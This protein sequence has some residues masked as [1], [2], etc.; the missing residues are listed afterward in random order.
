MKK[1][2]L[3]CAILSLTL[4][5]CGEDSNQENNNNPD[6][7]SECGNSV[8][9]GNEACDD[10]N[11][12]GGD[13]CSADCMK[14]E[15]GYTCP[16]SGGACSS[17]TP[18]EKK[19][20]VCGNGLVEKGEI[21]D[22]NNTND[23]DGC[24]KSC[25]HIE[26]GYTC[27]KK[28]GECSKIETCGNGNLDDNEACD[29]NNTK[30][31]DGCSADCSTVESGFHCD[32]PG[33]PC[34]SNTCN[35][36][37]INPDS[38]EECDDGEDNIEYG[39]EGMCAIDCHPAHYCGDKKLD[40]IDRDNGEECDAG[41]DTSS[42]YNGCTSTC[43]RI[44]Y[45]GD[46]KIQPDHEECD[47][48]N[49]DDNDGCSSEC[50]LE[51]NFICV[52]KNGKSVCNSV[53]C[54]NGKIDENEGCDDGNRLNGDGCSM[55]CLNEKGF[56]CHTNDSGTS[57]CD[58]TCGNG[59]LDKD[60]LET[61]D[62]GNT[63]DGDGCSAHCTI[64][65]GYIC[66]DDGC[67]AR[68]CSDGII[69]GNEECDDGNTID[70]DGC[71]KWCKRE[72]GWHCPTAGK[73]LKDECGDGIVTGDE[74]CDEGKTNTTSGCLN[75]QIQ[76]GW[77][78]PVEN[79]PCLDTADCGNGKMEGIE[80]CD[81]FNTV[82]GDGCSN[83]CEIETGYACSGTP[84]VCV[85]GP[86][87]DGII[88]AGE[89]CD[90]KNNKAGDGCSPECTSEMFFDCSNGICKPR[91]GDGMTMDAEECDDGNLIAGDGCSPLCKTEPGFACVAPQ[92]ELPDQI[93]LPMICR[94]FIA[95]SY[96]TPNRDKKRS[97]PPDTDPMT[98]GYVS[99][100]LYASLPDHCKGL[101]N[102][103][104]THMPIEVG[105]PLPDFFSNDHGCCTNIVYS[106]LD[107]DGLPKLR[108]GNEF[109]NH[110]EV[111]ASDCKNLFSCPEAFK[112]WY[113]DVPGLNMTFSKQLTLNK[114]N[115]KN[116]YGMDS[117]NDSYY[118]NRRGFYPLDGDEG[119]GKENSNNIVNGEFACQIE[120]YFKYEG[121]DN[122]ENLYFS[123][124]DDV[125]VF[126]NR[127]LGIEVAGIHGPWEK[128]VTLDKKTAK[129]QYHIYPG[130]IYPIHIFQAE[131]CS[132]G[133]VSDFSNPSFTNSSF[134]L[135]L[136]G[137]V[138]MGLS[139]CTSICGDGIVRGN[140]E[141]DFAGDHNDIELQHKFGCTADCKNAPFCKN[142]TREG[143][144]G[145]DS[146][147]TWCSDD[148]QIKSC[149][150]GQYESEH[151]ACDLSAPEGNGNIHKGCKANCLREGCGNGVI[152]AG[153][154]CDDG[155]LSDDD[156]CTS[157][158]TLPY[159]GDSIVSPAIGE[160]CDDGIN[161]GAYGHCGL[162]CS[163]SAPRC[164]DGILDA[165]E[166]CD[167]GKDNNVGG[168]GKCNAECKREEYCGDG[169]L[170]EVFEQCD[171]A[172][173]SG[174]NDSCTF[175]IN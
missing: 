67:I 64:E 121:S 77:E 55:I 143:V 87:G 41:K 38:G 56:R 96:P 92:N 5:A 147:E 111:C 28:G 114:Q 99:N 78:C 24:D 97:V 175:T 80:Q 72:K 113:T 156:M 47:D 52:T 93:V 133:G 23:G 150:N 76:K 166:E 33:Y 153:E 98:S 94:D 104:R 81:D 21:C 85:S 103:Y 31:E 42:E 14:T 49:T 53:L 168:Y 136:S 134:K 17:T 19:D 57:V 83:D 106:E 95:Y 174:C 7:V 18:S 157:K 142:G 91:C 58:L 139:T 126:F 162:G 115:N 110:P 26:D 165:K 146:T 39:T 109:V 8:I 48:E 32:T 171:P 62:D 89:E 35:D 40:K 12:A 50:K 148:C 61:C 163:Y 69:A 10:G 66:E 59:T 25:T 158:C 2:L 44:N 141:C 102:G 63:I 84:S 27:P 149:G 123:G 15:D 127:H 132:G 4:A 16:K 86:C 45:C 100:D 118:I 74:Q 159:C 79:M 43:Q 3:L 120:T 46:G 122:P 129:E 164:G 13:G 152:E 101:N 167:D 116:I 70:G 112:W 20:P 155:N 82:N 131:R 75:C 170:Q 151:E 60:A 135:T 68:A 173:S 30:S 6:T 119:Y 54:G 160:A 137:F 29:D 73:C 36:G 9:E 124:D 140:E 71:S 37:T 65:P 107:T 11:T 34:I 169:V 117:M 90:D 1:A 51:E 105:R 138:N 144:E 108:P 154:E 172:I 130:G 88:Q 145:C 22:D 128:S 161:D 125:W